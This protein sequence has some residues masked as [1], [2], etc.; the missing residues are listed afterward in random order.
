MKLK[1]YP[2]FQH[3]LNYQTIY[4][5]SDTHFN[6]PG[7]NNYRKNYPGDDEQISKINK[8]LGKKDLL[9][10]LGDVGDIEYIR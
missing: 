4:V 9:I 7:A 5:I 3:W 6:D 2:C 1:L 10:I 8:I